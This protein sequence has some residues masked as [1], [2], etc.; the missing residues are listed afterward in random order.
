MNFNYNMGAAGLSHSMSLSDNTYLHSTLSLNGA[1]YLYN[2]KSRLDSLDPSKLFPLHKTQMVQSKAALTSRLTHV[3]NPHFTIKG[4]VDASNLIYQL[5]GNAR[6]YQGGT[7][8]QI[9]DASGN[10]TWGK[11]TTWKKSR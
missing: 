6:D 3:F 11:S 10:S 9:L 1:E 8:P 2:E 7:F 5:Q 4:G